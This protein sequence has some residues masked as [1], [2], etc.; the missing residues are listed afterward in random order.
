M[1]FFVGVFYEVIL[2]EFGFKGS[3]IFIFSGRGDDI[4]GRVWEGGAIFIKFEEVYVCYEGR[5]DPIVGRSHFGFK[6]F[7]CFKFCYF[8]ES[9]VLGEFPNFDGEEDGTYLGANFEWG[10]GGEVEGS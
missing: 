1:Y 4:E 5:V 2:D 10:Y 7:S 9:L 8:F 6:F 3:A